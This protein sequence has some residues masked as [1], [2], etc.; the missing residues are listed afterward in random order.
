M[1]PRKTSACGIFLVFI[2]LSLCVPAASQEGM[3]WWDRSWSF[4]QELSLPISTQ[5]PFAKFQPID[6]RVTFENSCWAVSENH[7]SIRVCCWDGKQWSV[8]ESQIYDLN[9]TDTSHVKACSL[10]FLIP[11]LATGKEQYFVYYTDKET[12]P[13]D[14]PDHVQVEK[15]H[16]YYEPIPGQKADFDY[17]KITDEG[18]C[19]YGVG[20]Q[21]MMMTEYG[22]QMIFRQSKGQKD[23]SYQ[24]WD[25]LA[26]FCFQYRDASLPVGQDT[27]TTRMKLLSNEIFVDGNL[28]VEFGIVSTTSRDDAKTTDIYKYYYSPVDLKRICVHVTHEVLKDITVAAV[29]KVDGEYVFTSGFKTRS[30]ANTFLNTGEILPYIHYYNADDTVKQVTAD[31][32]PQSKN[33]EWLISVEDNADLGKYPWVSADSGETGKAHALIFSSNK[34]VKS[35][36]DEQDGIQVKA[37][38]KQEV[39]I[40]G[41]QAYSSGMGC[42]RNAY[43]PDGSLD[44]SIPSNLLVEFNGEFFTSEVNSYKDVESESVFFQS[45]I[46]YRPQLNGT[47]SGG[48]PEGKKYNLTIFTHFARSFPLGSLISAAS[49]KNFSYTYAELYQNESLIS[50]G[51]CSRISLA[52]GLNLDLT[53]ISIRSILKLFNWRDLTFFK[54]IRFPKL[55]PGTYVVK[56]YIK[57]GQKSTYVGVKPVTVS[58]DTRADVF[59]SKQQKVTVSVADQNEH[60]VSNCRCVLYMGD[61]PVGENATDQN[62]HSVL[63]VPRGTYDLKLFYSGFN[64]F[65]KKVRLGIRPKA[66]SFE[67]TLYNLQVVVKDKFGLPPG[68]TVTPVATSPEMEVPTKILPQEIE[69]GTYRFTNLPAA[70]Y[71]IQISYKTF[72]DEITV[73][74]PDAGETVEME[75]SPMFQLTT[76]V[77]DSRGSTLSNIAIEVTR[78]GKFVQN[79]TDPNG[80]SS[81]YIPVG[82][83]VVSASS[84][85]VSRAEKQV[86][87]LRDETT[88]LVTTIEPLY[89]VIMMIVALLLFAVG[90]LLMVLRK[91]TLTSFLK[92]C[93]VALCCTAVVLPWWG[94]SGSATNPPATKSINA[95]LTT[96]TIV[97]QTTIRSSSELELANIPAEFSLFLLAVLL[98]VGVSSGIILGSILLQ[99]HR[100]PALLL[101]VFGVLFL[102]CAVAIFT[103]GFSQLSSVGLG[104]LQGS[105]TYTVLDPESSE[106]VNLSATWGLSTGVYLTIGAIV[107]IVSAT[108][109]ERMRKR[110][111]QVRIKE[112]SL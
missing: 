60:G 108:V 49:G 84:E 28:M 72:L 45:L 111:K 92:L 52:G 33:E 57:S 19:V 59:C 66:E 48:A 34:V 82:N 94:L 41:L 7:S 23:F 110:K 8:L 67:A 81:F 56:I 36:T 46:K 16:Y 6:I 27:I 55:V 20:I 63:V 2:L 50:S 99:K 96:Q 5:L 1:I 104:S 89:P 15:T 44:L 73:R 18:L 65:E 32:N 97:T 98:L 43:N 22:S 61:V 109:V 38:Q 86:E 68:T 70:Q 95:Y 102:V 62:G 106:S 3:T 79:T 10:V 12:S 105:G 54:K 87:V 83:Y 4:R 25:R 37:S 53:N 30:E 29:E 77:F 103:Y 21:G 78:G 14:Y 80:V 71:T 112:S 31:T 26:S 100:K 47:V 35:G 90:I 13:A 39:D 9:Y 91:A 40:P 101:T 75:F 11:D 17:Y 42:F 76:T 107:L 64:L 69:P 74:V 93:S 85:G 51:I 58:G 24:Y 88:D